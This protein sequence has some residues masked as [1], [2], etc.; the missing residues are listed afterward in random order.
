MFPQEGRS[1]P[2]REDG[3]RKREMRHPKGKGRALDE[4]KSRVGASY[5]E[6]VWGARGTDMQP[7]SFLV[8]WGKSRRP[9][10]Q[11]HHL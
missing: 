5:T 9:S 3:K 7:L 1:Q 11:P 8:S 4:K 6:A 2:G 10:W